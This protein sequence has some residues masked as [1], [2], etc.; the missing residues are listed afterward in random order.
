MYSV[1]NKSSS[2]LEK[3]EAFVDKEN[4]SSARLVAILISDRKLGNT[5]DSP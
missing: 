5:L 3:K 1:A 4:E 2:L